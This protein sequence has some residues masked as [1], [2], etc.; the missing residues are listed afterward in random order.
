[1]HAKQTLPLSY[2]PSPAVKHFHKNY[3]A[4]FLK[5]PSERAVISQLYFTMRKSRFRERKVEELRLL[6][7][8]KAPV[9][10]M[11]H[12]FFTEKPQD[13]ILQIYRYRKQGSKDFNNLPISK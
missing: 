7:I 8:N 10:S 11:F 12:L 13:N 6:S 3:H 4:L 1:V 5:S 9:L 2:S